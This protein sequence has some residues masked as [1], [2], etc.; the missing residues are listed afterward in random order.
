MSKELTAQEKKV[1][2]QSSGFPEGKRLSYTKAHETEIIITMHYIHEF[3]K[4]G[5]FIADIGA[6]GGT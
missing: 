2:E 1:I 5:A 3:L 4:D 6:G